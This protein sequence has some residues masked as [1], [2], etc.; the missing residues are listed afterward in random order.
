MWQSVL[1]FH[2]IPAVLTEETHGLNASLE[3]MV[4][5]GSL[6]YQCIGGFRGRA[7]WMG[8]LGGHASEMTVCLMQVKNQGKVSGKYDRVTSKIVH[9]SSKVPK[10]MNSNPVTARTCMFS[11][12]MIRGK[13]HACSNWVRVHNSRY[14]HKPALIMTT[15]PL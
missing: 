6:W 12:D 11:I 1:G 10:I 15:Q 2:I 14:S 3:G 8:L 5:C 13:G 9:I 4:L 7:Y